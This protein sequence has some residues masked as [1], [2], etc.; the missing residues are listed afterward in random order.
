[1]NPTKYIVAAAL[2][3]VAQ[4]AS[5]QTLST[6]V[7]VDR[8]VEPAARAAS[9]P[10]GLFPRLVLP[11]VAPANLSTAAYAGIGP[12]TRAY[13]GLAPGHAPAL[14]PLSPYRGY[15]SIGYFPAYNLGISAGYRILDTSRTTLGV[16]A[17]FDGTAYDGTAYDGPD[18]APGRM[19]WNGGHIG[20][21]F[22]QA[23]GTRSRLDASAGASYA[24]YKSLYYASQAATSG[25][26]A[27]AW[28]SAVGSVDYKIDIHGTFDSYGD[29]ATVAA[30]DTRADA[31]SQQTFGFGASGAYAF[32]G[33]SR[34]GFDVDGCWLASSGPAPTL[35]YIG[36]T[37]F[38]RWQSTYFT[39]SLG[40]KADFTTGG[41]SGV[42]FAP[43]VSLTWTPSAIVALYAT[44]T[45]GTQL[46]S[47][48]SLRRYCPYIVGR[49]ALP[50][51]EVPVD[52]TVGFNFGPFNGITA[53]IFGAYASANDWIMPS[54]PVFRQLAAADVKAFRGG[55][56]L[57]YSFRSLFRVEASAE[58]AQNDDGRAWYMW[59][60][61]ASKVFRA[62][63]EIT[64]MSPLRITIGYEFRGGRHVAGPT[65]TPVGLGAVS[66][67]DAG[68][69]WAL[70]PAIGIHARVDNILG[71][72]HLLLPGVV[73]RGLHGLVGADF[74]F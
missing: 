52:A 37:P 72:R 29:L 49:D 53:G 48:G 13:I 55:L 64:P 32:N 12:V 25:N 68:A 7:V 74:K 66:R 36:L 26:L 51:S 11:A 47:I 6:E 17:Q 23:F 5:A 22:S 15:A 33:V 46:N 71:R 9:R 62:D 3:A 14:P 18:D 59:R 38:Y 60:D 63:A 31:P 56:R 57:G 73:S 67:L 34:A 8:T 42:S 35:G 50:R 16:W 21:D 58:F 4:C 20:V 30:P 19:A 28:T 44:A 10:S 41:D 65:G 43:K 70:T 27:A 39:A 40:F 69:R 2:A 24:R 54:E 61:R 45:G 1:M